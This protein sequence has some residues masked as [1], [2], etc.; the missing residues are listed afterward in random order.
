MTLY[1]VIFVGAMV[2]G[3]PIAFSLGLSSVVYLFAFD[4]WQLMI[5]F[6]QKMIAGI[7]NFVLLTIPFFILAGNLMNSAEL[8]RQIVRFAQMLVGRVKG[9]L[10]VVNVVASMM[11]SGVSGAATAEASAIGSIM[12]PAMVR[13]GYKA[14][15]AAALTATGSILG[16]LVPP[17]LSLILYGVLTGTSIS[18]LFL[19]GIVP[20]FALCAL[21]ICY[22]LWRAKVEDHPL[23]E[24]IPAEERK[25]LAIKALPALL[26]PVIIV[27]G[28]RS[29]VFT[30]TEA[31]AVAA[32]YALIIG[33]LLYRTLSAAK[34]AQTFYDTATMTA[35]VMLIVAMAS[36]TAFILGIENIP[37]A[38]AAAL[39]GVS[40]EPWV[41]IL[42]LNLVL[43]V[44]GLF[45][46][47]LAALVLAMPIL[48]E[49]FPLLGIDAVQFGIMVVL[50]LMIGMITPPVGLCLFIVS[51]I[52]KQPLEKVALAIL[53]MI[54]ICLITLLLVAFV[55]ALT[56]SLPALLG[57]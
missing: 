52:G 34:I 49:I 6:P 44:L 43:L 19:A 55:P 38:I 13:D 7:D 15:Y 1:L 16:P 56:L 48:N 18:D 29:G 28:I 9:G 46:E 8:T 31:A 5:G 2:L 23:P 37:R 26:L 3:I 30:P 4:R 14:A 50:N 11:F 53:P 12:I 32:L 17:S 24:A 45:L 10:A 41:L 20:A 35:G 21:L 33:G 22:A 40:E 25:G 47:P 36:M 51:A 54:A 57:G 27:G 42:L 39:R